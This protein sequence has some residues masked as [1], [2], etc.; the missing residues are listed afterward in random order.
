[1]ELASVNTVLK[2]YIEEE[3]RKCIIPTICEKVTLYN[4]TEDMTYKIYPSIDYLIRFLDKRTVLPLE[5][6][7]D[8]DLLM[9]EDISE[10]AIEDLL[11]ADMSN[12]QSWS[13][14]SQ[15]NPLET[16]R[17]FL[18]T[19]HYVSCVNIFNDLEDG[20]QPSIHQ[21]LL[22]Y[23]SEEDKEFLKEKELIIHKAKFNRVQ[24]MESKGIFATSFYKWYKDGEEVKTNNLN[25]VKEQ[26]LKFGVQGIHTGFAFG[27]INEKMGII[28]FDGEHGKKVLK[29]V[30]FWKF[31]HSYDYTE[32]IKNFTFNDLY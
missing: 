21:P 13:E 1:M 18:P 15:N 5:E 27:K 17:Q 3:T 31:R 26:I 24:K 8:P 10:E 2:E 23:F 20:K 6:L 32:L 7:Y 22:D 19:S 25:E 30:S 28:E 16:A 9:E 12:K 4:S 14:Y 29:H 11:A